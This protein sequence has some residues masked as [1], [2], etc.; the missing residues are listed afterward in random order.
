MRGILLVPVS[1]Q[2]VETALRQFGGAS[3]DVLAVDT[4]IMR[5]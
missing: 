2:V 3:V 1:A 5:M 4:G